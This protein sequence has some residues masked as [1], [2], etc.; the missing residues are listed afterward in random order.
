MHLLYRQ[1]LRVG[2]NAGYMLYGVYRSHLGS[3]TSKSKNEVFNIKK[4][5]DLFG[6][7]TPFALSR[8]LLQCQKVTHHGLKPCTRPYFTTWDLIAMI[9]RHVGCVTC[10][11]VSASDTPLN[12]S[13]PS[14][15]DGDHYI[16]HPDQ[17]FEADNMVSDKQQLYVAL[18]PSG[19]V[20]LIVLWHQ[21]SLLGSCYSL[22]PL[23]L[24]KH[25]TFC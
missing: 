7:I 12:A 2:G 14:E 24:L 8:L 22:H 25:L 19:V 15:N 11:T 1:H 6:D 10:A 5:R 20:N 23:H 9:F 3:I 4:F 13:A 17:L 21:N 18:Y 16:D